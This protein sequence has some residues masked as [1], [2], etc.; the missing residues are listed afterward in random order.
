[1]E[2][3]LQQLLMVLYKFLFPIYYWTNFKQLSNVYC[4]YFVLDNSLDTL[5]TQ[6]SKN[7]NIGKN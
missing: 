2:Y 6:I 3:N 1:M 7:S 4:I 5:I